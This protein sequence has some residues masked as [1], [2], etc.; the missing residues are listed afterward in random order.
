[1][2]TSASHQCEAAPRARC[3][4]QRDD[5]TGDVW[6]GAQQRA[7]RRAAEQQRQRAQRDR[8]MT[9]AKDECPYHPHHS[10]VLELLRGLTAR[11]HG[12]A[13]FPRTTTK[14]ITIAVTTPIHA[15]IMGSI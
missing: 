5:D 8:Q 2:I 13:R 9:G 3:P 10:P 15:R 7:R 6:V 14:P 11:R 1:M 12:Q 4:Q